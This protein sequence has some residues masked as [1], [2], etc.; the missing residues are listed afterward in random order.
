MQKRIKLVLIIS[1]LLALIPLTVWA[2]SW[3]YYTDFEI[4]DT[5]GSDRTYVPVLIST[6]EGQ[7]LIDA[8]RVNSSAT[9]TRTR[10]GSTD[11]DFVIVSDKIATLV[12][13]L[14][15]NQRRTYKLYMGYSPVVDDFD[16]ITGYSG[17]ITISDVVNLELGDTFEIEQKGYID[18]TTATEFSKRSPTGHTAGTAWA[19]ESNAYDSDTGTYTSETTHAFNGLTDKLVLTCP[20]TIS[21]YIRFYANKGTGGHIDQLDLDAYYEGAWHNDVFS[22]DYA[23]SAWVTVDLTYPYNIS[24]LRFEFEDDDTQ[25]TIYLY[26]VDLGNTNAYKDLIWKKDSFRTY[27]SAAGEITSAITGGASV[28]ATNVDSGLHEVKTTADGSDLT[29][30]I[31]D[32]VAGDGYD[33]AALGGVGAPDTSG[34][35]YI[36]I[37]NSFPSTEYIKMTVGATQELLYQPVAMISGTI[38]PDRATDTGT[39]D[40]GTTT[41]LIDAVLTE[42]NDYWNAMT[43]E[44]LTTT[45]GLA[46]Q[47]ETAIITDFVAADD[48]LQFAALTVAVEA[49]DT[50]ELR[51]EGTII[52]GANEDLT[53]TI[54]ATTSYESTTPAATRETDTNI[55]T[56]SKEPENWWGTGTTIASLPGYEMFDSA[57]TELGMPTQTLYVMIMLGFASAVGL[58]VLLFTG[59]ALVSTIAVGVII[60]IEVGTSVIGWWAAFTFALLAIGI[61]YLSR[62]T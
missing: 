39:V 13:T 52:W 61:L 12:P 60:G 1:F 56:P 19:N 59:S 16:I 47:S 15:A 38:L 42:A 28:T 30:S 37:G 36:A 8:G 27:I 45:D 2:D 21:S 24:K 50:Y 5:S 53:I 29:I 20:P 25:D 58:S 9:D 26:E 6:I 10:E 3:K 23:N 31:D 11:K 62:Q 17:G 40:S 14:A 49:G 32:A 34:L 35:W 7:N 44:I 55:L 18:T 48:E 51:N 54:G 4:E 41:T 57:A 43:L 22:A 46:P 33:T